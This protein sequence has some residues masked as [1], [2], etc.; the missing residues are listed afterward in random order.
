MDRHKIVISIFAVLVVV[1][2]AGEMMIYVANP[3][4]FSSDIINQD[5]NVMY[6]VESSGSARFQI[7][8][9]DTGR[10]ESV[11]EVY[12]YL[13]D[14]YGTQ[15]ISNASECVEDIVRELE[16][17]GIGSTVVDA[18]GL[19]ELMSSANAHGVAVVFISGAMP[20]TIYTGSEDDLVLEW[21]R[22]GG[23]IYWLGVTMGMY[24]GNSDGTVSEVDGWADLFYGEGCFNSSDSYD[25]ANVRGDDIGELLCL[26][27]SSTQF[28]MSV[29]VADS[30]Q[31]GYVSDDG[32]GSFS[33]AKFGDGM[34]GIVG[35][36]YEDSTRTDLAQAIASGVT[37][38]S[39]LIMEEEVSVRGGT[40]V[41]SL[42]AVEGA[43]VYIFSGGYYTCYGAR[44]I[45][46]L[47]MCQIP[48]F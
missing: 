43:T 2:V 31:L 24:V 5:G 32:Y 21:L 19:S 12:I 9:I 28:G 39:T 14:S 1:M 6:E 42:V 47:C 27:S 18:R 3:Y 46:D 40:H 23:S 33:M 13:D 48:A 41:G 35:G 7:L 16:I 44:Y 34:I 38:D 8:E 30:I 10:M 17:R 37:Y 45:L 36:Y 26:R 22:S 11:D 4:H 25:S 29:N 15:G 20:H